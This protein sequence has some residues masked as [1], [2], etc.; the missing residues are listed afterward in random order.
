MTE[1]VENQETQEQVAELSPVEQ[2]AVAQGWVPKEQFEG[3]E[4]KWV[5]AAEF[6]RRGE[7]FRKI[8][9]QNREIK[10][11]RKSLA[12]LKDHYTKVRETE[13]KRALA[14][15]KADKVAAQTDGEFDKAEQLADEIKQV[16]QEA[17][18]LREAAEE[19]QTEQALHPDIEAWISR[20]SW[21]KTN[22][23]MKV[24]A[25]AIGA[26]AASQGI[27]GPALLR[28]ID[29]E[30]RKEFPSKFINPN[31]DKPSS[32]ESGSTSTKGKSKDSFK[33][34][35]QEEKIMHSLVRDK[36]LTKEQYLADIKALRKGE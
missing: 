5:E 17:A 33:L 28:A 11:V 8:D 3:D 4:S 13:Y 25:D 27:T 30:I 26:E 29:V 14:V 19:V 9:S 21:Y 24:V 22:A 10:E 15:L 7:L 31:R 18:E 1:Q 16:E 20:N 35:E 32:V 2:E 23:R 6:V 36:V 12:A 34:T